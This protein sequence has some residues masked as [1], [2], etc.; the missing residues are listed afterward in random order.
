M[1]TG[2][3]QEIETIPLKIAEKGPPPP[4]TAREHR[5]RF[6]RCQ[7][8]AQALA[9]RRWHSGAGTQELDPALTFRHWPPALTLRH[10]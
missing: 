1:S 3:V 2:E 7:E 8:R 5:I 6:G 9:L 10:W 4:A